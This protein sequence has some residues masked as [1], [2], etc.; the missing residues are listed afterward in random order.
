MIS[1]KN[2][3][4]DVIKDNSK[5]VLR[6]QYL[7]L[8]TLG[9][10]YFANCFCRSTIV[11]NQLNFVTEYSVMPSDVGLICA[12]Y[13]V[14]NGVGQIINSIFVKHYNKRFS[15]F[16]PALFEATLVFICFFS[17]DFQIYK[18][19]WLG[20]GVCCSFLWMSIMKILSENLEDKFLGKASICMSICVGVGTASSILLGSLLTYLDIYRLLFLIGGVFL[21]VIDIFFFIISWGYKCSPKEYGDA[22]KTSEKKYTKIPLPKFAFIFLISFLLFSPVS[23]LGGECIKTWTQTI[24][25]N[26]DEGF[27]LSKEIAIIFTAVLPVVQS[28]CSTISV[29]MRKKGFRFQMIISVL[30]IVCLISLSI[31]LIS[32]KQKVLAS[33][34][35]LSCVAFFS[36]VT[37]NSTL[38]NVLPL[39]IRSYYDSAVFSGVVNGFAYVGTVLASYVVPIL[40]ENAGWNSVY[41]L[42]IIAAG[43]VLVISITLLLIFNKKKEYENI[44]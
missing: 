5:G 13:A 22:S 2:V 14:G 37:L 4:N 21:L 20:I 3:K 8:F 7:L 17:F 31:V 25:Y 28:F 16:L 44:V 26:P 39:Q 11:A 19:I 41:V 10:I 33:F 24:L 34:I 1:M 15:L 36:F 23:S 42:L 40:A 27:G 9:A 6:K 12:L 32:L 29:L 18:F 35:I 43:T 30:M 38:T